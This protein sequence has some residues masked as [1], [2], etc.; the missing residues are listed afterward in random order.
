MITNEKNALIFLL[1]VTS[2]AF[3]AYFFYFKTVESPSE[4]IQDGEVIEISEKNA[5]TSQGGLTVETK[6]VEI[7]DEVTAPKIK[8]PNLDRPLAFPSGTPVAQKEDL[9]KRI[10]STVALLKENPTLFNEW[11]D[12]GLFRKAIEDYTG[13]K[14]AWE[15]ASAI[16]SGNSLSFGNLAVLYGF[17]LQEPLL[18]EKN[19]LKA[20]ENDSKLPYLYLQAADFYVEVLK[21]KEKAIAILEKGLKEIPFDEALKSA[22]E[23]IKVQP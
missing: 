2:L 7:K 4:L 1:G 15:Y 5:S 18:A 19:Y 8:I 21:D 16:R 11:N 9:T 17:Y 3:S 13:A 20:I 6:K 22:L 12:L 14:E 10:N 23:S